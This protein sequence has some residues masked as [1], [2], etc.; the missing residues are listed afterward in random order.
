MNSRGCLTVTGCFI[1]MILGRWLGKSQD[2]FV[3]SERQRVT[4][5][6]REELDLVI[7]LPLVRLKA[8]WQI[9]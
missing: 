6:S 5:A 8:D 7:D 4:P 9:A 2:R 1:L 3:R